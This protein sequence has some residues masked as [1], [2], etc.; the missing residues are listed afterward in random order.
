MKKLNIQYKDYFGIH[1]QQNP[2]SVIPDADSIKQATD[3]LEKF[4]S[5]LKTAG[6]TEED[7]AETQLV[8]NLADYRGGVEYVVTDPKLARITAKKIKNWTAKNGFNLIKLK[9]S[10]SKRVGYF[11]F[12]LGEDVATEARKIQGYISQMPEVKYFR[13]NNK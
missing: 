11:Q 10:A 3:E 1:E 6:L 13:F 8:N 2:K 9:L 5:A 12:K 4:G 7:L